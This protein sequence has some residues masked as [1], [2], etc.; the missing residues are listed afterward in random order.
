MG[1][2]V[3]FDQWV[4]VGVERW[5]NLFPFINCQMHLTTDTVPFAASDTYG[6]GYPEPFVLGGYSAILMTA[7]SFTFAGSSP[8]FSAT[9]NATW[10]LTNATG[11]D[12]TITGAWLQD[13]HITTLMWGANFDTPQ[14]I[15]NGTTQTL[16]INDLTITY[17]EC[18]PCPPPF[19]TLLDDTMGG[20]GSIPLASHTPTIGGPWTDSLGSLVVTNGACSATSTGD[21]EAFAPAAN[22]SVTLTIVYVHDTLTGLQMSLRATDNNNQLHLFWSGTTVEI[23]PRVGGVDLPGITISYALTSGDTYTFKFQCFGSNGLAFADDSFVLG[24]PSVP[25]ALGGDSVGFDLFA[26]GTVP[27]G[28]ILSVEA[29]RP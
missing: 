28:K 10:S 8:T 15:P 19:T 4:P 18:V 1:H 23:Q 5:F 25:I 20:S 29:T 17:G 13:S 27:V 24:F 21:N 11:G 2:S 3:L 16:V 9:G 7:N 6:I 22:D 14:V 12:V 26:A